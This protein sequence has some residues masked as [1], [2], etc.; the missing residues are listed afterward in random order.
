V[1]EGHA[2]VPEESVLELVL[3]YVVLELE[4]VFEVGPAGLE[5][6]QFIHN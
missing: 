3:L 6:G 1:P 4:R 2:F 5:D